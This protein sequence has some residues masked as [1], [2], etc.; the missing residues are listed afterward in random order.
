M[1]NQDIDMLPTREKM[2]ARKTPHMKND[3]TELLQKKA[4]EKWLNKTTPRR[5]DHDVIS[6]H[7]NESD[8]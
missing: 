7:L 5:I 2:H 8:E 3:L 6:N 4:T 1:K